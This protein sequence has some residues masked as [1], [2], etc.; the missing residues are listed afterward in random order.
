MLDIA[1]ELDKKSTMSLVAVPGTYS[2]YQSNVRPVVIHVFIVHT[3]II[4][5]LISYLMCVCF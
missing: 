1:E 2:I 5:Y 4:S 3:G